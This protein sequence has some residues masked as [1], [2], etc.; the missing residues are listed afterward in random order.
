MEIKPSQPLFPVVF[1]Q[2]D[3]LAER[4][5]AESLAEEILA[6]VVKMAPELKKIFDATEVATAK[7]SELNRVSAARSVTSY[8]LASAYPLFKELAK[9]AT[10]S[11]RIRGDLN[12]SDPEVQAFQRSVRDAFRSE[13]SEV[14]RA[15]TTAALDPRCGL[16]SY[17]SGESLDSKYFTIEP[18]S[19][20]DAFQGYGYDHSA[21]EDG[22]LAPVFWQG[23]HERSAKHEYF[24]ELIRHWRASYPKFDRPLRVLD[25]GTGSCTSILKLKPRFPAETHIYGCDICPEILVRGLDVLKT[26]KVLANLIVCDAQDL[27]YADGVFDVVVNFGSMDQMPDRQKAMDEMIRV[28]A[29]GGL[30]ICRDQ[31]FIPEKH[32]RVT[33]AWF[34]NL[35]VIWGKPPPDDLTRDRV[36][37]LKT[38]WISKMHF[39]TSFEKR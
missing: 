2:I 14:F 4:Q 32:T 35:K 31:Q 37:K 17:S 8:V 9:L 25:I 13:R 29:P 12:L 27:P 21:E 33:N 23:F 30:G 38:E 39:V 24:D 16:D 34:N 15:G 5:I 26:N 7:L 36:K 3:N 10:Y 1:A 6:A 19:L 20:L 22:C 11:E 28:L 18:M